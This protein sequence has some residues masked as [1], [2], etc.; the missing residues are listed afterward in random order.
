MPSQRQSSVPFPREPLNEL[1]SYVDTLYSAEYTAWQGLHL[2]YGHRT[3]DAVILKH[4]VWLMGMGRGCAGP[5]KPAGIVMILRW[6]ST[7][8]VRLPRYDHLLFPSTGSRYHQ[9]PPLLKS[10]TSA[11]APEIAYKTLSIPQAL[12]FI[13]QTYPTSSHR[14]LLLSHCPTF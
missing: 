6:C 7:S 1:T 3:P 10:H 13:L 8:T 12:F 4:R 2:G 9:C 11:R 14:L 5:K